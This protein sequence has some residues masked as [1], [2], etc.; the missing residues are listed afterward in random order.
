MQGF[1]RVLAA[2]TGGEPGP[3][4]MDRNGGGKRISRGQAKRAFDA[5]SGKLSDSDLEQVARLLAA[6]IDPNMTD[7]DQDGGQTG[8]QPR[9]PRRPGIT[10][11]QALKAFNAD[12]PEVARIKH[13]TM[14]ML[15]TKSPARRDAERLRMALDERQTRAGGESALEAFNR[16][17]PSIAKIGRCY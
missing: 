8:D 12:W 4:A 13:D 5:V 3:A 7:P 15:V 16:E 6:C 11:D 10:G 1:T 14:G 9:M 17:W 2:L